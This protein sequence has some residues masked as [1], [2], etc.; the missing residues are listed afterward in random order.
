MKWNSPFYGVERGRWFLSFHCFATYVKLTFFD[1]D[2]LVP[3]PPDGSKVP[4]VRYL[5]IFEGDSFDT[6]LSA[7]VDQCLDLPGEKL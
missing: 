3:L 1:G 4:R 5:K 6:Q 7:W 2:Q